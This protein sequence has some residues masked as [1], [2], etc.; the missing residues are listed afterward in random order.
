MI[1]LGINDYFNIKGEEVR[2]VGLDVVD[3]TTPLNG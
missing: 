3:T 1:L 2:F